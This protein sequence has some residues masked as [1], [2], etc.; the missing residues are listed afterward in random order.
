MNY[1]RCNL[2]IELFSKYPFRFHFVMTLQ[3]CHLL[4]ESTPQIEVPTLNV[5]FI[6]KCGFFIERFI[7]LLADK[8]SLDEKLMD[9]KEFTE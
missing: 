7:K 5:Q 2:F 4:E 9:C 6:E 8:A 3:S 1:L